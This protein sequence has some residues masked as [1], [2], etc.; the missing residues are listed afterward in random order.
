MAPMAVVVARHAAVGLA[1]WTLV[2][3]VYSQLP[4]YSDVGKLYASTNLSVQTGNLVGIATGTL[5][6]RMH[7]QATTAA[8]LAFGVATA[9]V[10][11]GCAPEL[12]HGGA[13]LYALC[14]AAGVVGSAAMA[15]IFA[16][17]HACG[18]ATEARVTATSVG[19]GACGL[20]AQLVALAQGMARPVSQPLRAP[21]RAAFA[22]AGAVQV[23]AL[24]ALPRADGRPPRGDGDGDDDDARPGEY[25]PLVREEDAAHD[26][27][28]VPP[29]DLVL[30]GAS[31]HA[32][33]R[34]VVSSALEFFAPALLPRL[35]RSGG[36]PLW[37]ATAA[38][39]ATG[40]CGRLACGAAGTR[41]RGG[42]TCWLV[43]CVQAA[44]WTWATWSAGASAAPG[45]AWAALSM[46]L[47]S[48]AHGFV[49]T[50]AWADA[51]G[52]SA[53]GALGTAGQVGAAAGAL[54][55]FLAAS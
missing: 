42:T 20:F 37:A 21:P 25:A 39:N 18:D 3:V 44:L 54:A 49:V 9:T 43:L 11:V 31:V 19:A 45:A 29:A 41:A 13:V 53:A 32:L 8:V 15:C 1:S 34:V 10:L 14:F 35:V 27:G 48:A 5:T 47:G 23:L 55:G 6:R 33:A 7:V 2:S 30:G 52:A 40:I 16:H 38:W 24:A 51:G 26:T 22:V 36:G 50:A 46:G 17:A 12:A 4:R 28:E